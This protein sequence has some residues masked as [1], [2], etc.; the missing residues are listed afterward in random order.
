MLSCTGSY[1]TPQ[2]SVNR[3]STP[4]P[5]ELPAVPEEDVSVRSSAL[6]PGNSRPV[7]TKAEGQQEK[8]RKENPPETSRS[9]M[10]NNKTEAITRT[11]GERRKLERCLKHKVQCV[12]WYLMGFRYVVKMILFLFRSSPNT[13]SFSSTASS[14][15]VQAFCQGYRPRGGLASPG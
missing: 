2:R 8:I 1:R 6:S 7:Q 12:E 10:P 3:H 9:N 11:A 13:S 15:H 5:L 14:S 4:L